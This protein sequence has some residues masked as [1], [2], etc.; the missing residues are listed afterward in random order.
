MDR[1]DNLTSD[2]E[3]TFVSDALKQFECPTISVSELQSIWKA[4]EKLLHNINS[5]YL[6]VYQSLDKVPEPINNDL[7]RLEEILETIKILN[8]D[9]KISAS[10]IG[11]LKKQGLDFS[12]ILEEQ[13]ILKSKLHKL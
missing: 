11:K 6:T 7:S 3:F 8:K 10:K 1:L 9:K 12:N 4:H 5:D 13:T 2:F